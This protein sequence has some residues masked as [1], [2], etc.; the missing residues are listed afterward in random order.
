M[1]PRA[2][3]QPQRLA[4]PLLTLR[5]VAGRL[6]CSIRTVQRYVAQGLLAPPI[7]LT[8]QKC[9]WRESDVQRFLDRRALDTAS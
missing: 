9:L 1:P 5:E 4:D 2:R 3:Y 6:R 7:R 8:T